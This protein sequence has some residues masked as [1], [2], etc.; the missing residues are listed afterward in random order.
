MNEIDKEFEKK[1]NKAIRLKAIKELEKEYS[2]ELINIYRQKQKEKEKDEEY[3]KIV[4]HL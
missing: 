2:S 1:Y 4:N 3:R